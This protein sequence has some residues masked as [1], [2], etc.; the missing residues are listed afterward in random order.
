MQYIFYTS[1]VKYTINFL[2]FRVSTTYTSPSLGVPNPASTYQQMLGLSAEQVQALMP[3]Q[4]SPS[5]LHTAQRHTPPNLNTSLS[6]HSSPSPAHSN[7]TKYPPPL[8]PVNGSNNNT[9]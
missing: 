6:V 4:T 1:P 7:H 3:P 5:L 8:L 2:T 9:R